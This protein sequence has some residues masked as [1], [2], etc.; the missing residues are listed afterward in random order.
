MWASV[1]G[2]VEMLVES[3]DPHPSPAALEIRMLGPLMVRRQGAALRLPAHTFF[4][5]DQRRWIEVQ[6]L[7]SEVIDASPSRAGRLFG[8]IT[9][10]SA[11]YF[12]ARSRLPV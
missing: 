12:W 11:K 8:S 9:R 6:R 10:A 4:A 5:S 2:S 1:V 3:D 7:E